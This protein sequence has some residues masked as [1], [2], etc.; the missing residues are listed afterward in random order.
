[1]S[2]HIKAVQV[3]RYSGLGEDGKPVETP[4]TLSDVISIDE[5]DAPSC[6]DG[7]SVINC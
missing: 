3:H 7:A 2:S 4:G 6:N 5:I 1:M